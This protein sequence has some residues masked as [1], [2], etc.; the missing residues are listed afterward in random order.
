MTG[1]QIRGLIRD[2]GISVTFVARKLGMDR[3]TLYRR[4]SGVSDFSK[5]ESEKLSEILSLR[6]NEGKAE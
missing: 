6:I 2:K 5:S 1:T 3:K 4:F